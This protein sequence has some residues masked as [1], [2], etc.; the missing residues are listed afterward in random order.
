MY[1]PINPLGDVEK[2]TTLQG[3]PLAFLNTKDVF[4]L[5][6]LGGVFFG[7]MEICAKMKRKMR[8]TYILEGYTDVTEM[9]R[10]GRRGLSI[11]ISQNSAKTAGGGFRVFFHLPFRPAEYQGVLAIHQ[12]GRSCSLTR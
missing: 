12:S 5:N 11:H 3:L 2:T 8:L 7:G 6:A 9:K 4:F 10:R 1:T